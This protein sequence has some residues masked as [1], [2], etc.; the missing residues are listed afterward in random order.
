MPVYNGE[1]YVREALDSI[2][3]QEF[4]DFE[5]VICD[6]A[7]SD[8]TGAICREYADR[9]SRIRYVLNDTNVGAAGNFKRAFSFCRSEYFK[10]VVY[11]DLHAPAYL[12][13][14]VH[15]LENAPDEVALVYPR[16]VLIDGAG[17]EIGPY[18]DGMDL[19]EDRASDRLAKT[20]R[21]LSY[22]HAAL[23][24][25]RSNA[26]AR[27][28]VHGSFESADKIL[29]MEVALLGQIW[30]VPERLYYRRVHG[31]SSMT[32][33][34]PEELAAWIDPRNAGRPVYPIIRQLREILRSIWTA[35][36]PYDEKMAC[37]AVFYNNWKAWGRFR[38]EVKR[39][40]LGFPGGQ[41]LRG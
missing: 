37:T 26:L 13:R 21:N 20:L 22:C 12:G 3:A 34:S 23:G 15:L 35:G 14:C 25:Y 19:R 36:I 40:L 1:R 17:K 29:L 39:R 16:T 8:G 31:A 9:D 38:G 24:V 33:K 18:E 30:E 41:W 28:R 6:N 11:D 4:Q 5:L 27:T 10:W 2:L 32:S 7:S